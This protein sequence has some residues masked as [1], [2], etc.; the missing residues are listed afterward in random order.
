MCWFIQV[1][2]RPC[3]KFYLRS[4][5]VL[6]FRWNR[7]TRVM[8]HILNNW[9]LPESFLLECYNHVMISVFV[10]QSVGTW[11]CICT[12]FAGWTDIRSSNGISTGVIYWFTSLFHCHQVHPNTSSMG[13]KLQGLH[14]Y[15]MCF[16]VCKLFY[17]IWAILLWLL[18]S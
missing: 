13:F 4:F 17:F 16:I 10:L 6:F 8:I 9:N 3:G 15:I 1:T 12:R 2:A 7:H 11:F 18:F 14:Q 5:F